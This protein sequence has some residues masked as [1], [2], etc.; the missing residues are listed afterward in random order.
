[1]DR[2]R[3]P[4]SAFTLI[5]LL[6]VIAIIAILIGLLVPA[7]QKVREAAARTQDANNLKQLALGLHNYHDAY[8]KF[9]KANGNAATQLYSW[10]GA[11][12]PYIEQTNAN[13]GTVIP[14]CVCPAD[15]NNNG[16]LNG[17]YSLTSYVGITGNDTGNSNGILS[18]TV[19]VRIPQITDG[20]SNTIMIG[21]RP[22]LPQISWG[23]AM[24]SYLNDSAVY[25]GA[26]TY[27]PSNFNS[28]NLNALWSPFVTGGNF[29]FGDGTVHFIPYSASAITPALASRAGGETVDLSQIF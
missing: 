16:Q 4:R 25:C 9:P 7:V 1:M 27:A 21:P 23:W 10:I 17:G 15:S 6:V 29:A 22:P 28:T 18:N 8:K 14:I 11:I 3:R 5:E 20:T 12:R 2:P 19:N 24:S 26:G 13:I